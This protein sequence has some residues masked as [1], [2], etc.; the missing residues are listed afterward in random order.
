MKTIELTDQEFNLLYWAISYS[1]IKWGNTI[2]ESKAGLRP[3]I[4]LEGAEYIYSD[5]SS[6]KV[7]FKVLS[8]F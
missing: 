7:R 8:A 5:L 4:S 6:L 1:M 2:S 3:N